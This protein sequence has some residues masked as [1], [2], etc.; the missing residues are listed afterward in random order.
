MTETATVPSKI[1]RVSGLSHALLMLL[2]RLVRAWQHSLRYEG[3][4]HFRRLVG[5]SPQGSLLLLWHNR[6]FPCVG[7]LMSAGMGSRRIHALVSASRDGAQL[8]HF[9]EAQGLSVVRGSSSRRG[10]VAAKQLLQLLAAGHHVAITVD[11][12]RGP[13]YSPQPGAAQL[14]Q[15]GR[16]LRSWDQFLG[17]APFSRV[18]I[19][20]ERHALPAGLH[21][22]EQRA[23]IQQLIGDRL[24]RL[25]RDSHRSA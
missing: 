9:L 14:A 24:T 6:L 22:R 21:G 12:P 10:A 13:R 1:H 25:T 20:A 5:E 2:G 19:K 23:A 7:G 8:A 11:G 15:N 17:P 3:L 16:E 18:K 4:E